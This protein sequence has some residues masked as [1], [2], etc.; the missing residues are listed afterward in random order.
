MS[1]K[2]Q[3]IKGAGG[4]VHFLLKQRKYIGV[5]FECCNIY[6]RVYIN[7]KKMAYIGYCPKCAQR[8]EVKIDK[9][10]TDCRFFRVMK[11]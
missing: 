6:T 3:S 7:K 9:R 1:E 2:D 10:G 4:E 11:Y 8:A 5:F